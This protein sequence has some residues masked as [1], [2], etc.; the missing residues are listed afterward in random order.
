MLGC[1]KGFKAVSI[2]AAKVENPKIPCEQLDIGDIVFK[3]KGPDPTGANPSSF[4][5][6]SGA[7]LL[8]VSAAPAD[9]HP[10]LPLPP[11]LAGPQDVNVAASLAPPFPSSH[12]SRPV[13]Q[14]RLR[15]VPPPAVSTPPAVNLLNAAH[16]STP[17]RHPL[18]APF[19]VPLYVPPPMPRR[20]LLP[21]QWK[22]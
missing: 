8:T 15:C 9:P 3:Y 11:S 14:G 22:A 2:A 12:P 20:A 4:Q 16:A 5:A 18:S 10:G 13:T 1:S 6:L 21:R 17:C 19:P 7:V